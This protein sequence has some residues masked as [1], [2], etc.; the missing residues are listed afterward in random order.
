MEARLAS[1]GK[2]KYSDMDAAE[3]AVVDSFQGEASYAKVVADPDRYIVETS[4]MLQLT[5]AQEVA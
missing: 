3:R 1:Y 2:R 5:G 4:S